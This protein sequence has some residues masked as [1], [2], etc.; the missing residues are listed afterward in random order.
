MD[1]PSQATGVSTAR[2]GS[3]P[4]FLGA[5]LRN[6]VIATALLGALIVLG[7]RNLADFDSAL[8]GYTFA[9]LFAT[10]GIVYRYTVWLSK[11]PTRMLWRRSR[12]KA[13]FSGQPHSPPARLAMA[14][15]STGCKTSGQ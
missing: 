14:S 3:R 10:F 7:S 12:S 13:H 9:C 5:A 2:P 15:C 4:H 1:D 8:V 6:G 11:P